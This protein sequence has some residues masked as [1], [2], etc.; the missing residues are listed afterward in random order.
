MT[1]P[2]FA[3][4]VVLLWHYD[5]QGAIGVIINRPVDEPI[6]EL[7]EDALVD[8]YAPNPLNRV[9]WGGPVEQQ[10]GTALTDGPLLEEE[11]WPLPGN[12]SVTRSADA[13]TRLLRSGD[14]VVLCLGYAGWGPGQLDDEIGSGSWFYADMDASLVLVEADQADTIYERALATLG[15]D[16]SQVWMTPIG[17]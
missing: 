14:A 12:M 9:T 1:D 5:E 8:S 10:S 4:A 17:E 3:G 7:L 2:N 13:L 15:L 6:E 16:G 11:G